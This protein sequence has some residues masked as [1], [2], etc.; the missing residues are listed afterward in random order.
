M[1]RR[2]KVNGRKVQMLPWPRKA[3]DD[4]SVDIGVDVASKIRDLENIIKSYFKRVGLPP[5]HPPED[6]VQEILATI[7]QR[8]RSRSA[9]DPRKSSF[10]HYVWIVTHNVCCRMIQKSRTKGRIP[11]HLM[12]SMGDTI[13]GSDVKVQDVLHEKDSDEVDMC[14]RL[15]YLSGT[16]PDEVLEFLKSMK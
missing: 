7:V 4:P 8:N 11:L 9:F 13:P 12:I 16:L 15:D 3:S 10:G 14:D 6:I 1:G 5:C 2:A